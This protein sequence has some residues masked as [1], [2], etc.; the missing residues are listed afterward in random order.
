MSSNAV[1]P[2]A[3]AHFRSLGGLWLVY[4]LLRILAAVALIV[5]SATTTV[6]FGALL[7]RVAN[8]FMLM[9]IFHILYIGAIVL[10]LLCGALGLLAGMALM[11]GGRSGRTLGLL[12]AFFSLCNLPFGTTLGI[13]TLVVLLPIRTK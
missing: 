3:S 10:A 7:N 6:M 5:C 8:P 11:S 1:T 13:Y 9:D 2:N 4:G 12:A